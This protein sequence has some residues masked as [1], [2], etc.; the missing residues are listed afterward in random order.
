MTRKKPAI[1]PE[2]PRVEQAMEPLVEV[3]SCSPR[4]RKKLSLE[5]LIAETPENS[6]DEAWEKMASVGLEI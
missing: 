6:R 2:E 4:K 5:I 3:R 1:N